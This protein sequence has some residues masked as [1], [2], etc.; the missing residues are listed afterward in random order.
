MTWRPRNATLHMSML[1]SACASRQAAIRFS[2]AISFT[3][4]R[5]PMCGRVSLTSSLRD[6]TG[7]QATGEE[8]FHRKSANS[9]F[10]TVRRVICSLFLAPGGARTATTAL[11]LM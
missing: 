4:V 5:L 6:S 7:I 1:G 10:G 2:G 8:A 3:R 9:Y 11:L